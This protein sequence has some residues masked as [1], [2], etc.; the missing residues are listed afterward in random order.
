MPYS[1]S[2]SKS[3]VED[4]VGVGALMNLIEI[5]NNQ[6]EYWRRT[7]DPNKKRKRF[8]DPQIYCYLIM[9]KAVKTY[10]FPVSALKNL[11]WEFIFDACSSIDPEELI[12]L[13]FVI[14]I[15]DGKMLLLDKNDKRPTPRDIGE[16]KTIPMIEI[17]NYLGKRRTRKRL[18]LESNI[19]SRKE[20]LVARL[21][22][23]ANATV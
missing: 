2:S 12:E 11:D 9:K 14:D 13:D 17:F 6:F 16:L 15:V 4:S 5:D 3:V 23:E 20:F 21:K 7:L 1:N 19:V 22:K 8:F 10:F 18:P